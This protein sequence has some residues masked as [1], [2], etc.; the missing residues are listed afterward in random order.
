MADCVLEI[1][2]TTKLSPFWEM[3]S[4]LATQEIHS[5]LQKAKVHY[6]VHKSLLSDSYPDPVTLWRFCYWNSKVPKIP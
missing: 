3:N 1:M 4:G 5:I 2:N 6:R